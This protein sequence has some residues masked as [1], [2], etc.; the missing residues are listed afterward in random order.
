MLN[1]F[2]VRLLA[3]AAYI[4]TFANVNDDN[5]EVFTVVNT[6]YGSYFYKLM[7]YEAFLLENGEQPSLNAVK[8]EQEVFPEVT[9]PSGTTVKGKQHPKTRTFHNIP[10]AQPPIGNLR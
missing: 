4:A 5:I 1:L 7:E 10:Y 2:P 8:H 6:G 3:L 9:L